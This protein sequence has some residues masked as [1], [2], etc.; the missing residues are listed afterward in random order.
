MTAI[1]NFHICFIILFRLL[2]SMGF[3]EGK[4]VV[5]ESFG[6]ILLYQASKRQK[7]IQCRWSPNIISSDSLRA[8]NRWHPLKI[9]IALSQTSSSCSLPTVGKRRS[10]KQNCKSNQL[11]KGPGLGGHYGIVLSSGGFLCVWF[12]FCFFFLLLLLVDL[13]PLLIA[14]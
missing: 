14:L 5:P 1:C 2:W 10:F 11:L 13:L 3:G 12:W 6:L 9:F 4:I 8:G 7:N